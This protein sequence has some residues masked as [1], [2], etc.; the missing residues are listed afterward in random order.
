MLTPFVG[1]GAE[2]R[3]LKALL[4]AGRNVVVTGR[5]GSGRTS[6]VRQF[7]AETRRRVVFLDPS[8]SRATA[9]AM[10]ARVGC[11][12]RPPVLVFDD[13]ARVTPQWIR[14]L[15]EIAQRGDCRLVAI[16]EHALP[17]D[18]L[19]RLRAALGAAAVLPVGPLPLAV[20]ETILAA[21]VEAHG[22]GWTREDIRFTARATHGYALGMRLTLEEA[23][24]RRPRGPRRRR[25]HDGQA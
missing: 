8:E 13:V 7:A 6:L 10:V 4:S 14:F 21:A 5:F 17:P 20:V 22:L 11:V 2:L 12:P 1:R 3:R 25:G 18:Q 9:L 19:L 16:A 23:L 24:A 15:G